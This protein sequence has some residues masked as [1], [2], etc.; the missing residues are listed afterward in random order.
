MVLDGQSPVLSMGF[1]V[2]DRHFSR[3]DEGSR[4]GEETQQD[5]Q[6]PDEL[7]YAGGQAQRIAGLDMSPQRAEELLSPVTR[8]E[9]SGN[10]AQYCVKSR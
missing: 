10:D 1:E 3:G 4:S 8:E 2:C 9:E 5:Q 7:D 6:T